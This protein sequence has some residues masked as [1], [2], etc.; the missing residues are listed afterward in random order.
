MTLDLSQ[1]TVHPNILGSSEG[2]VLRYSMDSADVSSGTI[3]DTFG[4]NDGTINGATTGVSSPIG[5]KG[6]AF[7]FDGSGDYI[8]LGSTDILGGLSEATISA[9]FKKS[10]DQ[11]SQRVASNDYTSVWHIIADSSSTLVGWYN[12]G[13]TEISTTA[14]PTSTWHHIVTTYNSGNIT[15]YLDGVL[16]KTGDTG[17]ST[18]RNNDEWPSIGSGKNGAS[19]TNAHFAGDIDE[20]RIYDRA[21]SQQE[22]W[23]LYNIGRHGLPEVVQ[24]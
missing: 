14:V 7:S 20:V 24:A 11:S 9:W 5:Y 15:L 1:A 23:M 8:Q 12:G 22:V 3:T 19:S 2:G 6:E 13:W 10:S 4:S 17:G 21:L 18:I 16:L